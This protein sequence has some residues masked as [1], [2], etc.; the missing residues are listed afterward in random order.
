MILQQILGYLKNKL[1]ICK[2]ACIY[3]ITNLINNKIYIGQTVETLEKRF[4]K[5]G[6]NSRSNKDCYKRLYLYKSIN[7]YGLSN[8]KPEVIVEGDYNR[9]L[10][11]DLEKHYIRLYNSNNPLRGYNATE[12][13][14]SSTYIRT[15]EIR[16][17]ISE[18]LKGHSYSP[19]GRKLSQE[20]KD[21][22][23]EKITTLF[24]NGY[25]HSVAKYCSI[26]DIEGKLIK[27][28]NS[29]NQ[30]AKAMKI[31]KSNLV[32]LSKG[33]KLNKYSFRVKID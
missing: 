16:K 31:A 11:N 24:A 10:L 25:K 28:Y 17:R 8:F 30:A 13:G 1:Y 3:K 14:E 2:M 9:F 12:G 33:N 18:K 5:H 7:K 15:P 20:Q 23:S 26:L 19:K 4:W 22:I 6:S 27:R 32:E 21:L 29:I